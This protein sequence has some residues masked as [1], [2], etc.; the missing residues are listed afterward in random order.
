MTGVNMFAGLEMLQGKGAMGVDL[1]AK[2][3]IA[4]LASTSK[5][6]KDDE[7]ESD[8]ESIHSKISINAGA[9]PKLQS[10]IMA[11]VS[12]KVKFEVDWAHHWLGKEFEVNPIPFYQIRL[13]HY[14]TEKSDIMIHCDKPKE[15]RARLRLMRRLGYWSSK[16]DRLSARNVYAAIIRGLET[17]RESWGFDLRDYE[18]ILVTTSRLQITQGR[19]NKK[20]R[21]TFFLWAIPKRGLQS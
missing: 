20:T 3:Q 18:D 21:E 7:E 5:R 1:A 2:A 16:Y 9:K 13:S 10:G 14:I 4:M 12:H 19:E 15:L 6:K 11:K 8:G 17:G